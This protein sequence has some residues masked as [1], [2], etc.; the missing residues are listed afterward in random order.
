[1]RRI[2]FQSILVS[3]AVVIGLAANAGPSGK[4]DAVLADGAW[5]YGPLHDGR[6]DGEGRLVSPNGDRYRGGFKNGLMSG[7][8]TEDRGN[9]DH[10]EGEMARGQRNGHGVLTT[11]SG[12]TYEGA[13]VDGYPQGK[14]RLEW[15]N[16]TVYVGEFARGEPNGQGRIVRA[17]GE[18]YVG[19][20]K[21]GLFSGQGELRTATGSIY[22]GTYAH[23]EIV[24]GV[25][26]GSG[27]RHY[28]GA[29]EHWRFEGQ[30]RY[31]DARGTYSGMFIKGSLVTGRWQDSR[32]DHY[33]GGFADLDFEGEGK[34]TTADGDVYSG[35]FKD[36]ALNGHGRYEGSDG[37]S[38]VGGFE[39]WRYSGLGRLSR[40]NGD[41][42]VG[43]FKEG[44]YS[45]WG[46]LTKMA[47]D[48]GKPEIEAG[49]WVY[50]Q[51]KGDS[52]RDKAIKVA[53][54]VLY[55]Q[56]PLL[57]RELDALKPRTPDSVNMYLVTVAG[58]GSQEVFRREAEYVDKQFGE[59]FGTRGRAVILANSR[60]SASRLPMA[61]L[62]SLRRTLEVVSKRMDPARDILFLYLTSHGSHDH[63]FQLSEYG[64]QLADLKAEDLAKM[65]RGLPFRNKV[66]VISACYSGGFIK[67]L[68]D[69]HTLIITAARADRTSFGCADENDFTY[70][71]RAFFE[72]SVPSTRSFVEAY[73]KASGLVRQWEDQHKM[74]HHSEPQIHREPSVEAVLSRWRKQ[75]AQPGTMAA[76]H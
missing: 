57:N 63:R 49:Q 20:M 56:T 10:Y 68:S 19:H 54:Q 48:G 61:T 12:A 72:E 51:R 3:V 59:R 40:P 29:F 47:A 13:F 55:N 32:G 66:V 46:I 6:L 71:G 70:F 62:E 42:Y 53:A 34:Y 14:G 1:M 26:T 16:G 28:E 4:P 44:E 27:K 5:Y 18:V 50:G 11:A 31:R 37:E 75:A 41:V 15:P 23:G 33:E 21:D 38:Y 64:I 69:G 76:T 25:W 60:T 73:R 74:D 22:K 7:R 17:N 52:W 36:G 45:G 30:G 2:L 43:Q 39:H 65:L 9:G 35:A 67:P 8:G 58:N 24:Q